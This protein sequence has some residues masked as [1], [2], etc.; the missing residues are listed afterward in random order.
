[1][2][3]FRVMHYLKCG[4][5]RV[6]NLSARDS[7]ILLSPEV[8]I[9]HYM[10]HW[11][12]KHFGIT[13]KIISGPSVFLRKIA[14]SQ[15]RS[16]ILGRNNDFSKSM[17]LSI[18]L[19]P[20]W[21]DCNTQGFPA[22]SSYFIAFNQLWVLCMPFSE[23]CLSIIFLAVFFNHSSMITDSDRGTLSCFHDILLRE[24]K[25][26]FTLHHVSYIL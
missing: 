25:I 23:L 20:N 4:A 3:L 2:Y 22:L 15:T 24:K 16:A 26:P 14:V 21:A 10:L 9:E 5:T 19:T 13:Q 12:S 6:A 17:V 18:H 11:K 7:I 8:L 1:M